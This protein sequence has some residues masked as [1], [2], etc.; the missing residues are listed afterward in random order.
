MIV[1]EVQV[2]KIRWNQGLRGMRCIGVLYVGDEATIAYACDCIHK[3]PITTGR[4]S[5]SVKNGLSKNFF[6]VLQASDPL[7]GIP[8]KEF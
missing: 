4:K 6:G 2:R 3:K 7:Y 8:Q 5:T 1:I